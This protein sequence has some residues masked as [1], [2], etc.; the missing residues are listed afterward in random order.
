[1][2]RH[3]H[4]RTPNRITRLSL[5]KPSS[6]DAR[7]FFFGPL[8]G[9]INPRHYPAPV[10]QSLP[11]QLKLIIRP[12]GGRALSG[13]WHIIRFFRQ[14]WHS[15][16]WLAGLAGLA[17][18]ARQMQDCANLSH[19]AVAGLCH[20]GT[21]EPN[22]Q[23]QPGTYCAELAPKSFTVPNDG[24]TFDGCQFVVV[25]THCR[26]CSR[27]RPLL[28]QVNNPLTSAILSGYYVAPALLR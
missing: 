27:G 18:V 7:G 25:W 4:P 22:W 13:F 6:T 1:V 26:S 23:R 8:S 19:A 24:M 11:D 3:R 12:R 2:G 5:R 17:A 10:R 14:G 16:L 21:R 20:I 15:W 9:L 28:P